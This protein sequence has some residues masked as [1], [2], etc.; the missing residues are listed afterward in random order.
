MKSTF[1]RVVVCLIVLAF[2]LS[3][4]AATRD[5]VV[6]S[7]DG[8]TTFA[9]HP[10]KTSHPYSD[11]KEPGATANYNNFA[12]KYPDGVYW[13]CEGYTISGPD[14][15][16]GEQIWEAAGFTATTA[17]ITKVKFAVG[18]VTGTT[19]DVIVS[20]AADSGS[21]T[22]GTTLKSWKQ[23]L[24]TSEPFGD[25]C[26]VNSKNISVPVTIGDPYW[27]TVTTETTSDIWAAWNLNDTL[28][29]ST[30]AIPLAYNEGSG[31]VGY[32][33]YPGSAFEVEGQ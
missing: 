25:C 20:L 17:T 26:S 6:V 16:I 27:I 9:T 4:L 29:L 13:C 32:M 19:T 21:G 23:K 30:D 8:R 2:S 1:G 33:G 3:A 31:W 10:A 5:G 15:I 11:V 18:Y 12:V 24:N 22:P 28:Q 7:K 14:S